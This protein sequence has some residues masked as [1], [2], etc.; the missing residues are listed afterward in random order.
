[1]LQARKAFVFVTSL[2][3][4]GQIVVNVCARALLPQQRA[5]RVAQQL[6]ADNVFL[7]RLSWTDLPETIALDGDPQL[8]KRELER[9]PTLFIKNTA[10]AQVST[11]EKNNASFHDREQQ[12]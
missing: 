7:G 1:L 5:R 10:P 9:G 6:D 4:F 8:S 11:T 12:L 2:L 3:L